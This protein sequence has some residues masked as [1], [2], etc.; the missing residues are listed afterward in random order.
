MTDHGAYQ[1]DIYGA[2]NPPKYPT[3]PTQWEAL[4]R[5]SV[6]SANFMYV[7]GSAT[8]GQTCRANLKAFESRKIIPR[9]LVDARDKS[10]ETVIL[11]KKYSSPIICAP[12]GVQNIMHP[13]GEEATAKACANLGI[14]YTLSSASTRSIEQ[15]ADA[16][17]DG[18][19]WYQLYWPRTDEITI[20]LLDRAWKNGYTTLVVTLDTFQLGY[21]PG[22]LDNCE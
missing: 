6:P 22:D 12:V 13:D 16:S 19:R 17:G 11:G 18:E 10:T 9:M 20:S 3:D 2:F 7:Y 21:R 8:T 1:L 14:P 15:V 5:R 4:A